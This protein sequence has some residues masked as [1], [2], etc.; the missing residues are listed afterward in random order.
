MSIFDTDV[1]HPVEILRDEVRSIIDIVVPSDV[2]NHKVGEFIQET[3]SNDIYGM[4]KDKGLT[5]DRY[6]QRIEDQIWKVTKV[7]VSQTI[8]HVTE[9][10]YRGL[11]EFNIQVY[12]SDWSNVYVDG[13]RD[14]WHQSLIDTWIDLRDNKKNVSEDECV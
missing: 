8:Q 9:H 13:Q 5:V 14:W 1:R 10:I 11:P 12:Y 4:L 6:S 3:I 2:K 7:E